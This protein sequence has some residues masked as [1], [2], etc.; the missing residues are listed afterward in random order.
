MS[1]SW[2]LESRHARLDL[3]G[4]R[5][6]LDLARPDRGLGPWEGL[7]P[8]PCAARLLGIETPSLTGDEHLAPIDRYVHGPDLVV[9]Y[10]G[11]RA[12]PLRV[13]ARWRGE[14]DGQSVVLALVISVRTDALDSRPELSVVSDVPTADARQLT[15]DD[16]PRFER[17]PRGDQGTMDSTGGRG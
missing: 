2:H 10:G 8:S 14:S 6:S 4:L 17:L 9:A 5:A 1:S 13:D 3:G 7:A 11:S 16:R 12:W 15:G